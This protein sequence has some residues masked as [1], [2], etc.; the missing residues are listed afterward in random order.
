MQFWCLELCRYFIY[1][2]TDSEWK[3]LKTKSKQLLQQSAL[4]LYTPS[5]GLLCSPSFGTWHRW[6]HLLN[7][8][9]V[10]K[11]ELITLFLEEWARS[12]HL[13]RAQATVVG[14]QHV[15]SLHVPCNDD[16]K[17]GRVGNRR[18][19]WWLEVCLNNCSTLWNSNP[20]ASL[21][22]LVMFHYVALKADRKVT[23]RVSRQHP[24]VTKYIIITVT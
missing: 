4:C 15:H 22:H 14:I 17:R 23:Y 13:N 10:N 18:H 9:L 12:F 6:F 8:L 20:F 7:D 3:S 1:H 24:M 16:E 2:L 21:R 19:V 5:N 11:K